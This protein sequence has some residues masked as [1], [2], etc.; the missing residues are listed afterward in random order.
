MKKNRS[1]II[2]GCIFL[3]GLFMMLYPTISNY[4]N[5]MMGSYSIAKYDDFV[6]HTSDVDLLALYNKAQ[7]YNEAL[8]KRP[9]GI[10][11]GA[12][13]DED[14]LNQL[15]L[16]NQ[17]SVIAYITID[18]INVKLPIYHG[19]S[20]AVLQVGIG[21]LEGSSL[22]IGGLGM[23]TVLTG[24]TGLPSA[25]LFTDINQLKTGDLIEI[26]VLDKILI[27]AVTGSRVVLPDNLSSLKP[28]KN[29]D[30]LTLVT[31]T[32]YGINS[33]RLLVHASRVK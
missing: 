4:Y 5:E 30:R 24:H 19:S 27:Y 7:L 23:H 14:Y 16:E 29:E 20:S 2:I 26:H 9:I 3:V 17:G 33:H 15:L 18:K 25:K 21:H 28:V 1:N 32:P 31:C 11:V 6:L 13:E 8:L 22:P 10:Q 12:S